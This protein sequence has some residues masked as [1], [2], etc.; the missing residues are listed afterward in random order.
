[1]SS[2]SLPKWVAD[3]IKNAQ[4]EEGEEWEGSG[5]ILDINKQEKKIDVQFYEKLPEGRYIATIDLPSSVDPETLELATVYMFKFRA[6]KAP[7]NKKVVDFLKEKFSLDMQ[8]I[9][10]FD[11]LSIVKLDDVSADK[12]AGGS[13]ESDDDEED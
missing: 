5:Y 10:K 1:M 2:E 11:L 3:E 6:S 8:S 7:L 13:S 9:Y 4:F 12:P